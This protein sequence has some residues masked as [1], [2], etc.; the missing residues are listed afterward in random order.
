M[1]GDLN[2]LRQGV[3]TGCCSRLWAP[4]RLAGYLPL[5]R[6]R[7]ALIQNPARKEA[8]RATT[9]RTLMSRCGWMEASSQPSSTELQAFPPKKT[10]RRSA[11]ETI[12]SPVADG[13]KNIATQR[14]VLPASDHAAIDS[15][16]V[17]ARLSG[18]LGGFASQ[19]D[20]M[21]VQALFRGAGNAAL[22]QVKI[23][24]VTPG[25]REG[26]T[27]LLLRAQSAAVPAG[28]RTILVRQINR[29]SPVWHLQ[30]RLLRQ[31]ELFG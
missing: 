9:A 17:T 11:A 23:G 20:N 19:G 8:P 27:K 14:I 18:Y 1:V 10:A 13:A 3:G 30:R 28:T 26:V 15:G 31:A 12:S 25:Q 6:F 21:V 22:G 29:Y 24:P 7:L 4:L 5:R 16:A 2:A